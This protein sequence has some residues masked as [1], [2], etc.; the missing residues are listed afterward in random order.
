MYTDFD[1]GERLT[2]ASLPVALRGEFLFEVGPHEYWGKK[3]YYAK[4]VAPGTS[5][6]LLPHLESARIVRVRR[7]LLVKGQEVL[8]YASKSKGERYRSAPR[9]RRPGFERDHIGMPRG[10]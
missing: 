4:L 2:R 1:H 7:A 5:N 9:R 10:F 8:A 3:P 6:E